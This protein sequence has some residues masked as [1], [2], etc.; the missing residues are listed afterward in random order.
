VCAVR[1]VCDLCGARWNP[2]ASV[3]HECGNPK[4][5]PSPSQ[6]APLPQPEVR[7]VEA[8]T[9]EHDPDDLESDDVDLEQPV[10][11]RRRRSTLWLG[12]TLALAG[13]AAMTFLVTREP[14]PATEPVETPPVPPAQDDATSEPDRPPLDP[15]EGIEALAGSWTFTT[16]VA[17]AHDVVYSGMQGFYD[18]AIS[19]EGCTATARLTKTGYTGGHY[20]ERR[21]QR[22]RAELARTPGPYEFGFGG[23]FELASEAKDKTDQHFVF[24]V[25]E[26]LLFGVW[27]QRGSRW[28]KQGLSGFLQG[29]REPDARIVPRID[30]QPCEIRCAVACDIM[31]FE[32]RDP[33]EA[34]LA[35]CNDDDAELPTCGEPV[36]DTLHLEL[37]D[38][39]PT[40]DAHC[41][42]LSVAAQPG[43]RR[44]GEP[45]IR[46]EKAPS[47]ATGFAFALT[48]SK[49]EG[50]WRE[51]RF[52]RTGPADAPSVH[53]ALRLFEGWYVSPPLLSGSAAST[54]ADGRLVARGLAEGGGRGH[55]LGFLVGADQHRFV[56]CRL[57]ESVPQCIVIPATATQNT[58]AAL[59]G[60]MV[61]AGRDIEL[62]DGSRRPPGPYFW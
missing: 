2:G 53:L 5:K 20:S 39:L 51:V 6:V 7:S 52:L 45:K 25:R 27:S 35:E 46:C 14:Q 61:S 15:C 16:E 37:G 50:G 24:I 60:G 40:L 22:G 43:D 38:P 49:L 54:L 30:S 58:T 32:H 9:E 18:L 8:A 28:E 42:R 57:D 59:P 10:E 47:T 13:V 4:A 29:E 34:C 33:L 31:Q 62:P 36:P 12:A 41:R 19:V 11:E 21:I 48:E 56:Q 23:R 55:V 1:E 3:C 17:A 44:K 26:G